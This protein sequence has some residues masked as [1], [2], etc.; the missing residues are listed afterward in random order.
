MQSEPHPFKG[1][2]SVTYFVTGGLLWTMR[3]DGQ[4]KIKSGWAAKKRT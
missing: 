3:A 1:K 4:A 2:V